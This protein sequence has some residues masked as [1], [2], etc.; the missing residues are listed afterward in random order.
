M[1]ARGAAAMADMV[2]PAILLDRALRK[3]TAILM[4]TAAGMTANTIMTTDTTATVITIMITTVAMIMD[5]T[6][7]AGVQ[8]WAASILGAALR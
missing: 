1:P 8:P 6:I 3:V 5:A 4:N 2:L 7:V